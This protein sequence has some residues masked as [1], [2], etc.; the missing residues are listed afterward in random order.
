MLG[1][2]ISSFNSMFIKIV[3]TLSSFAAGC[4]DSVG[5]F[6]AADS[7]SVGGFAVGSDFVVGS[8]A[9]VGS[10]WTWAEWNISGYI[11]NGCRKVAR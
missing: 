4:S 10:G 2:A 3:L 1:R 5:C 9:V 6:V 8:F 7:D 11:R